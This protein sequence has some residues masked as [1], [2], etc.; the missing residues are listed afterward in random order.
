M[1]GSGTAAARMR[2][3]MSSCLQ[4]PGAACSTH[5]ATTHPP[6]SRPAIQDTLESHLEKR[7][8]GVLAP[9]GGRRL[10][11]FIDDLNMPARS[12]FGFMPPLELIKLWADN[13][14]W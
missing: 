5:A 4:H 2:W 10:V 8:K 3:V 7:T 13:G 1:C 11:A 12:Q 14:F 9:P 6:F